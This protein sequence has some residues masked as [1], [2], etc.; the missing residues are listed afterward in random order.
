MKCRNCGSTS[1]DKRDNGYYCNYCGTFYPDA[2]KK[3]DW[4]RYKYEKEMN[5]YYLKTH[6]TPLTLKERIVDITL[7]VIIVMIILLFGFIS[8]FA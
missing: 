4:D 1:F 5:A 6:T 2:V 7:F 3:V 8:R